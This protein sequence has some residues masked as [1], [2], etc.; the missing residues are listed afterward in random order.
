[1]AHQRILFAL[2]ISAAL[3][4]TL[5]SLAVTH[6]LYWRIWWFDMPMH[7]LGGL[8]AALLA[9]WLVA[10]RGSKI[11]LPLCLLF[12]LLTG[13][14]WELFEYSEGITNAYHFSYPTDTFKDVSLGLIGGFVGWILGRILVPG[15]NSSL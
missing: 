10:Y 7:A 5:T 1:M 2:L 8:C 14:A 3:L 15:K 6:F 12:A 4:A 11:S 13:I 9:A